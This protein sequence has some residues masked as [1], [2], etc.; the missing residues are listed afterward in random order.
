ML[1]PLLGLAAFYEI[2]KAFAASKAPACD[3][4]VGAIAQLGNIS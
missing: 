1:V 4:H 3:S 2:D